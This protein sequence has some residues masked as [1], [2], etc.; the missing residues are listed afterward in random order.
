MRK[1]FT[2]IELLV[3]IAIIAILAAILFPVFARARE[4]ARQTA[5]LSNC[6]QIGLGVM[7]YCQD[8]SER[9]PPNVAR[10]LST[11]QHWYWVDCIEPYVKNR[12]VFFCPSGEDTYS[13]YGGTNWF[14]ADN[15]YGANPTLKM[16][17]I[18][19]PATTVMLCEIGHDWDGNELGGSY[20]RVFRPSRAPGQAGYHEPYAGYT[21]PAARHNEMA[22]LIFADGHAKAMGLGAFF[23]GQTP[24]DRWF[25]PS[26]GG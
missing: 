10:D 24:I 7:M 17:A 12:Q 5:C 22:N 20:F 18:S 4:K 15:W 1:G 26:V 3:V 14:F 23:Y 13:S 21:A 8:Y 6:K 9:F 11:N 2:L 25:D 19:K 16:A